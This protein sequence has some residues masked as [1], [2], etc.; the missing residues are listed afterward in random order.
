MEDRLD[1]HHTS[2]VS[3]RDG[4]SW[5]LAGM[6]RWHGANGSIAVD[7]NQDVQIIAQTDHQEWQSYTFSRHTP[8]ASAIKSVL[9]QQ[10]CDIEQAKRELRRVV[11]VNND[12]HAALFGLTLAKMLGQ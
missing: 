5:E 6:M 8:F 2:V 4:T 12:A 7:V 9:D 1:T 10:D 3:S 11:R